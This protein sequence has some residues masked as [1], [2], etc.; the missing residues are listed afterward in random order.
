M[1]L[2]T[3]LM[4]L[5]VLVAL[6]DNEKHAWV[7]DDKIEKLLKFAE[8]WLAQPEAPAQSYSESLARRSP[9]WNAKGKLLES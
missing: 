9:G 4:H 2:Q 6:L 5:Y 7:G 8:G 1:T 3:L